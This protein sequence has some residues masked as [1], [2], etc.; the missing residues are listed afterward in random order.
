MDAA[1]QQALRKGGT[2]DI[3]TIGRSSGQPH[4]VEIWFHSID[5]RLYI[6]GLPGRRD[7]YANLMATPAFTFHLKEG[8]QADLAA[9]AVPITADAERRA[10]FGVLLPRL[11][12]GGELEVWLAQSPL[13]EVLI[14]G[15]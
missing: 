5:E 14:D 12:R 8:V 15:V 1:V 11:G 3:T 10:V 4:R 2:I 13:V 6:T 9:R 7:W